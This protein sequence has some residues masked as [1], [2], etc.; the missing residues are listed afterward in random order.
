LFRY[1]GFAAVPPAL[2]LKTGLAISLA[3]EDFAPSLAGRVELKWPNDIMMYPA[4]GRAAGKAA[5]ILAE[6]D[7]Q[8]MCT[9]FGVNLLQTEF[10]GEL[11]GKAASIALALPQAAGGP[12]DA[13]APAGSG[14]L[15]PDDRFT[16]L[17]KILTR[18]F[19]ELEGPETGTEAAASWLPRLEERL[20]K[21]GEPVRFIAGAA[22]SGRVVEGVLAGIGKGGE[23]LILPPGLREPLSFTAGELDVYGKG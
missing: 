3:I 19:Q 14:L 12:A 15:S 1:P 20:Y 23:L 16:L 7:G 4:G 22:G 13:K 2:T 10:P 18:L 21:R 17:E 11:R 8:T 9:G 6:G 5:G